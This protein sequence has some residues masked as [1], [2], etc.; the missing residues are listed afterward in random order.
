M[1]AKT[2]VDVTTPSNCVVTIHVIMAVVTRGEAGPQ[3]TLARAVAEEHL[4]AAAMLYLMPSGPAS[5]WK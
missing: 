5:S 4:E 1:D 3:Y 2:G